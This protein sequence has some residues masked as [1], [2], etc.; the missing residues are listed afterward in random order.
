VSVWPF[1]VQ[2]GKVRVSRSWDVIKP[3]SLK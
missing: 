3:P 2:S 1:V